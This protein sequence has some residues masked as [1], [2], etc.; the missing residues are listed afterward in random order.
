M[1]TQT[2]MLRRLQR[3]GAHIKRGPWPKTLAHIKT[4]TGPPVL[5]IDALLAGDTY[6]SQKEAR[7][8][9]DWANRS[10]APV[11]SVGCPSGVSGVDGPATIVDGEPLAIRP[12]RIVSLAAPMLGLL[13]AMKNGEVWNVSVADI[14]INITLRRDEAVAFGTLWVAELK[15]AEEEELLA[16]D[17]A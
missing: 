8:M 9:I 4:L 5:I 12:D 10:R 13:E 3:A 7:D 16:V 17:A 1:R 6:D 15:Y 14:G 2:A 11:L